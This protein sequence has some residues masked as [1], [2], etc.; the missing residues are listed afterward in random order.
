MDSELKNLKEEEGGIGKK[1]GKGHWV[2]LE[3]SS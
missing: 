3:Q 2:I 1:G